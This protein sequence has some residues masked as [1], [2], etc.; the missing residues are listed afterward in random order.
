[1]SE[2]SRKDNDQGQGV[3]VKYIEEEPGVELMEN[4]RQDK[5]QGQGVI[6]VN[7]DLRPS[8]SA[9]AS[10]AVYVDI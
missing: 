5:D 2:N 10:G 8:P 6:V 9:R 4:S 1:M 7:Q 3:V